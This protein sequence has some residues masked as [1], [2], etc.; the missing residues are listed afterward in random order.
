M[1][2]Q[3][4]DIIF[5]VH[6]GTSGDWLLVSIAFWGLTGGL[7]WAFSNYKLHWY[8]AVCIQSHG[9]QSTLWHTTFFA[10]SGNVRSC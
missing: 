7:Y 3:F 5:A 4:L 8:Q 9:T 1:L 6:L 10:F 2:Q